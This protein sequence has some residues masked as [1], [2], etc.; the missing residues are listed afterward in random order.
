MLVI[1]FEIA[2]PQHASAETEIEKIVRIKEWFKNS[3]YTYK[4][5]QPNP[6]TLINTQSGNCTAFAIL[7]QR[8]ATNEGLQSRTMCTSIHAYNLVRIDGQEYIFDW[9]NYT[10]N[11]TPNYI[12]LTTMHPGRE[13]EIREKLD[14]DYRKKYLGLDY[15]TADAN[16]GDTSSTRFYT[17][18]HFCRFEQDGTLWACNVS[19][20]QD[21]YLRANC[22]QMFDWDAVE[23]DTVVTDPVIDRIKINE[24]QTK[25]EPIIFTAKQQTTQT[26]VIS[27]SPTS[28]PHFTL[29]TQTVETDDEE[30]WVQRTYNGKVHHYTAN[31]GEIGV[32]VE[33]HHWTHEQA[34]FKCFKTPKEGRF[35]I[36]RLYNPNDKNGNHLLTI[37][38]PERN[39]LVEQG[40]VAEG[41]EGYIPITNTMY[42]LYNED[43]SEHFYTENIFEAQA[44]EAAGWKPDGTVW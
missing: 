25:P 44:A 42:R 23:P 15:P 26:K 27:A 16:L 41:I 8:I 40:W 13:N 37:S 33:Q 24:V 18:C 36:C 34:A 38:E 9:C 5:H 3:G 21:D 14:K 10:V 28:T 17:P 12:R 22:T 32:L 6:N 2:A 35:P 30:V 11:Y 4:K 39:W 7:F 1:S 43:T 31:S 29:P 20:V 19:S